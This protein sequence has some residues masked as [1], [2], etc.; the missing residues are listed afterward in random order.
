MKKKWFWRWLPWRKEEDFV[1][2]E[3]AFERLFEQE[4]PDDLEKQFE[5][6]SEADREMRKIIDD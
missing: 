5:R 4:V 2:D 1:M 3:E 6:I